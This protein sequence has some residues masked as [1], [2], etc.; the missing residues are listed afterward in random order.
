MSRPDFVSVDNI[1]GRE[2]V[3]VVY[4]TQLDT[5]TFLE[6]SSDAPRI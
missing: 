4:S 6:E 1:G 2:D 5:N 3:R